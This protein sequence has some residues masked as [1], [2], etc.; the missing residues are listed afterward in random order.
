MSL[1]STIRRTPAAKTSFHFPQK[2]KASKM[3]G[4]LVQKRFDHHY[5]VGQ[6]LSDFNM[7]GNTNGARTNTKSAI[8]SR[9]KAKQ[10]TKLALQAKGYLR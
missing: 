3:L 2:G 9:H 5:I 8:C 7:R 1:C 10:F 4:V 6:L